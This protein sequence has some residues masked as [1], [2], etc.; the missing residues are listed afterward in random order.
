MGE[1]VLI[2]SYIHMLTKKQCH[3]LEK[4]TCFYLKV[5]LCK[6]LTNFKTCI[7]LLKKIVPALIFGNVFYANFL[8]I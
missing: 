8:T 5:Y 7:L 2:K 4:N 1:Y 6:F 3:C